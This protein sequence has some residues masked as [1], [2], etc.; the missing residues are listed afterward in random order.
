MDATLVG[1]SVVWTDDSLVVGWVDVMDV[2]SVVPMAA[3]MVVKLVVL[4]V[5]Q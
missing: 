4:M 5:D 3:S 1:Q 2:M